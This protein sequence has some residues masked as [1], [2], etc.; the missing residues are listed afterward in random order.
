MTIWYV[1]EDF[2]SCVVSVYES[3]QLANEHVRRSGG[4]VYSA[5]VMSEVTVEDRS[6]AR[7]AEGA[8][9]RGRYEE[10]RKR[11]QAAHAWTQAVTIATVR[12]P[13]LCHCRTF[14]KMDMLRTPNGYCTYCGGWTPE[15]FRVHCG[16]DALVKAID[17]L[18]YHQREKMKVLCGLHP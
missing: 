4:F 14:S 11:Q 13:K 17:L 7:A 15:V 10:E 12:N 3:E 8:A 5:E 9:A 6:E 16:E 2:D 18:A 1:I